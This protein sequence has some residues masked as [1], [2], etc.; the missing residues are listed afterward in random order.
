LDVGI[1]SILQLQVDATYANTEVLGN[2]SN[3]LFKDVGIPINYFW[4]GKGYEEVTAA[5]S[6]IRLRL[7]G[8]SGVV[9]CF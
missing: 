9:L 3:Q 6:S 8:V 2:R 7:D 4:K 5:G 1:R